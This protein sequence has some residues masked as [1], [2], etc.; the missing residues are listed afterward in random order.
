[1]VVD[2]TSSRRGRYL[3]LGIRGVVIL[4]VGASLGWAAATVFVSPAESI[5]EA[6]YTLVRV[7]SGTVGSTMGLTVAAEWAVQHTAVNRAAGVLTDVTVTYGQSVD[8]GAVIFHVD[9]RPVVIAEGAVPAYRDLSYGTY[10]RDVTQLQDFLK[11]LGYYQDNVDG[12]M[13]TA[14]VAA[15][16][17]WQR[18]IGVT[19]S[20]VVRVSDLVFVPTLPA[21]VALD[22]ET[23]ILGAMLA[24]GE[25]VIS[26][27]D[28]VPTFTAAVTD[29]QAGQIPVGTTVDIQPETDR[30]PWRARV[31][32]YTSGSDAGPVAVLTG[33]D[34]TVVCAEECDLVPPQ[35]R[36]VYSAQAQIVSPVEGL[37]VPAAALVSSADGA[38]GLIAEDGTRLPVEVIST[39]L[40][41][42]VVEG[43]ES[44]VRVRVPAI[45]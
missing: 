29:A 33:L 12:R 18:D 28:S 9:E 27:L 15:T 6:T 26:T 44:G 7:E 38:I 45:G 40:G 14:T 39:A 32:S 3:R 23:M 42:S 43:V 11:Q 2:Q 36:T 4:T 19:A 25:P 35:G 22:A 21:R 1:M 37:V 17:S 20:G 31:A 30:A 13:G 34:D 8:A 10:G 24:G 5:E 16:K 41:M